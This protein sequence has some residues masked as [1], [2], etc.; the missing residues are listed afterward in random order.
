MSKSAVRGSANLETG[1]PYPSAGISGDAKLID[2]QSYSDGLRQKAASVVEIQGLS[3]DFGSPQ[4][5]LKR[6]LSNV[7]M[8]CEAGE[9]V[10]LVGKS[11]CGKTTILNALAGLVYPTQGEVRVLGKEPADARADVGYMFARDA[12]MPWRTAL[13]N[14]QLGLEVRGGVGKAE[15]R[16]R[17]MAMLQRVGLAGA[18]G[19]YPWQLSHGMRQRVALARTWVTNPRLLLMDEP[20]AALDAQTRL[21]VREQFLDVWEQDRKGVVFV[22]HDL[23]EALVLAD[24]ILVIGEGEIKL[25]I[26]VP[27]PRP[28]HEIDIRSDPRFAQIERDVWVHLMQ[29]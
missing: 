20:F 1:K 5:G 27:F 14:V 4:R 2:I 11:G 8:R 15:R 22:T 16:D 6:V 19:L 24:R 7:T 3:V 26:D 25:Q 12:L 23:A 10:A 17:S 13:G 21:S 18:A 28:R 29:T 9:F